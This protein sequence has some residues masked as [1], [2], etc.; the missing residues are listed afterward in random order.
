MTKTNCTF[1]IALLAIFTSASVSA[2]P[3]VAFFE[4]HC[5]SCHDGANKQGGLD[6]AA[7][8]FT[9]ADP[10]NLAKWVRI[11]DRVSSGEMPPKKKERPPAADLA[12]AVKA[13]RDDIVAAEKAL[14]AADGKTRLRRLT[15]AEYE[16]TVRDLFDLPGILLQNDLPAD[17][18]I[19]GFDKHA[20]ALDLSHVNL[21]KYLEAADR[22]LDVAIA[23]RP[24]A[25]KPIKQRV[26]LA[27]PSGFVAHVLMNGDGVLLK[28]KKIDPD[29]PPAGEHG[30]IDQGAHE[31]ESGA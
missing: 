23:T 14:V 18:S 5:L 31:L 10:E 16:N 26:S 13:I 3:P 25:P 12:A 28:D 19:N 15:R 2:A 1:A 7:L 8:K 20:D 6:L 29:F 22:V 24:R 21:A 4:G 11:H 27:N 17:G 30:H 9:P